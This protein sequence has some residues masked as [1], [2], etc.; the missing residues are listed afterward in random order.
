VESIVGHAYGLI[1][2]L[3]AINRRHRAESLFLV[4]TMSVVTSVKTVGS[5][6]MPPSA[7]HLVCLDPFRRGD[8]GV[9]LKPVRD[10][11]K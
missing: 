9:W 11:S 1:I 10:L 7:P 2:G 5:K 4:I 3:E 6:K 8:H